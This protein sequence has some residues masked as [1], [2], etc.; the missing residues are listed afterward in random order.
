MVIWDNLNYHL[1]GK[2]AYM[3]KSVPTYVSHSFSFAPAILPLWDPH[4]ECM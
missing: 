3:Y 1:A 2:Q 4:H